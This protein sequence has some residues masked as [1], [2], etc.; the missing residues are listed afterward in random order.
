[1]NTTSIILLG[2]KHSGKS[3]LGLRLASDLNIGFVDL[4][5]LIERAYRADLAISCREIYRRHGKQHFQQLET[6]AARSLARLLATS[7]HA[8]ALGGGI[9]DNQEALE[10]LEGCG[11]ACYL[12]DSEKRLFARIMQRGRPAFLS[13]HDPE[14]SFHSLFVSRTAVYESHADLIVE[15]DG[16]NQDQAY[17]HLLSRIM[18][19]L[20]AR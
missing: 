11:L 5:T 6:E 19:T 1:M 15:I 3:T 14:G 7:P 4:D 9:A 16:L 10:A 2:M 17:S 12:K 18:E 20:H 8:A 13:E